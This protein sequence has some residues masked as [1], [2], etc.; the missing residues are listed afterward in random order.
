M[1]LSNS[2]GLGTLKFNDVVSILLKEKVHRKTSGEALSSGSA[3]NVEGRGRSIERWQNCEMSKSKGVSKSAKLR[4]ECW[5][6]GK[7]KHLIRIVRYKRRKSEAVTKRMKFPLTLQ[8]TLLKT[9]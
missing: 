4:V 7:K 3:L 6:Y 1:A 2:S 5:N 8:V 9:L